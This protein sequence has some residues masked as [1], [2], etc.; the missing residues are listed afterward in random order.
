LSGEAKLFNLPSP[1]KRGKLNY[2]QNKKVF[3]TLFAKQE[4]KK[5]EY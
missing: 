2:F 3:L 5:A 4:T 1:L